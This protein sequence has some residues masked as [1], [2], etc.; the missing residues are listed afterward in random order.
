MKVDPHATSS[1]DTE[2]ARATGADT[3]APARSEEIAPQSGKR[4]RWETA[5]SA[6]VRERAAREANQKAEQAKSTTPAPWLKQRLYGRP[7]GGTTLPSP[8]LRLRLRLRQRID[9]PTRGSQRPPRTCCRRSTPPS[10]KPRVSRRPRHRGGP[11]CGTSTGAWSWRTRGAWRGIIWRWV[12]TSIP[13]YIHITR[14]RNAGADPAQNERTSRTCG[15]RFL[16][17]PSG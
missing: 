3:S 5:E 12:R 11:C 1:T 13:R 14:R 15:L 7:G 6:V 4:P 10:T 8:R 16:S 2:T 17:P 9:T